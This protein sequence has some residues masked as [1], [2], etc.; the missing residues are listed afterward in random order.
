MNT[1]MV[2]NIKFEKECSVTGTLDDFAKKLDYPHE[3]QTRL[4]R[5]INHKIASLACTKRYAMYCSLFNSLFPS[6]E[7]RRYD[8][9]KGNTRELAYVDH[10]FIGNASDSL[11]NRMH[12]ERNIV[13]NLKMKLSYNSEV[14]SFEVEDNG[15]GMDYNFEPLIFFTKIESFKKISD[16]PYIGK[17]GEHMFLSREKI[18]QCDGSIHF[19]NKGPNQGARFWYEIPAEAI[20]K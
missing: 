18:E 13:A 7:G 14:M 2:K 15:V 8:A 17:F 6:S 20:L 3:D 4:L 1:M 11:I 16:L 10:G 5:G 12:A 19:E 9:R